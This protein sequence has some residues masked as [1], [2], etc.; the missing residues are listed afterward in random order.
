MKL[1]IQENPVENFLMENSNKILSVKSIKKKLNLN[2][3]A[4]F[5]YIRNSKNIHIVSP[6]EVGSGR[7][8]LHIYQYKK[9]T[10]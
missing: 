4:I 8:F 3:K 2:L 1:R 9:N 5:F 10:I 6:N 7:R